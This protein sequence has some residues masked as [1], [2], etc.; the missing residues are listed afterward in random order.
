MPISKSFPLSFDFV[1][2]LKYLIIIFLLLTNIEKSWFWPKCFKKKKLIFKKMV[3][4]FSIHHFHS[5]P[6]NITYNLA[7]QKKIKN[8]FSYYVMNIILVQICSL[9]KKNNFDLLLNFFKKKSKSNSKLLKSPQISQ[10]CY[11]FGVHILSIFW[12]VK[13]NIPW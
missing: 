11:K 10:Y 1:D 3:N 5:S 9:C 12:N 13:K 8:H 4:Y 2:S 6:T 7:F